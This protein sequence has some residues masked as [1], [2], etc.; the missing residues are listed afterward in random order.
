MLTTAASGVICG[1]KNWKKFASQ[2]FHTLFISRKRNEWMNEENIAAA[3]R[4][5]IFLIFASLSLS[6][7]L[8]VLSGLLREFS[9]LNVISSLF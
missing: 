6:V 7:C 9:V 3:T 8:S 2:V 4:V 1:K 5:A